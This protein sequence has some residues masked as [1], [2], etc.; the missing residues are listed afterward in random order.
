MS[1][2]RTSAL[3]TSD[4]QVGLNPIYHTFAQTFAPAFNVTNDAHIALINKVGVELGQYFLLVD[5]IVDGDMSPKDAAVR[6]TNRIFRG[7][8]AINEIGDSLD[9]FWPQL[10]ELLDRW[11]NAF[12][13]EDSFRNRTRSLEDCSLELMRNL[14][15]D[16]GCM[17]GGVPA[18][19]AAVSTNPGQTETLKLVQTSIDVFSVTQQVS[20]DLLDWPHDLQA[21]RPS[22]VFAAC[23]D[24]IDF[25][26]PEA[27]EIAHVLYQDG[28]MEHLITEAVGAARSAAEAVQAVAP[29]WTKVLN[30]SAES[31]AKIEPPASYVA[32]TVTISIPAAKQPNTSY[33]TLLIETLR[34]YQAPK[35]LSHVM[36][37]SEDLGVSCPG[38]YAGDVFSRALALGWLADINSNLDDALSEVLVFEAEHLAR[39]RDTDG[40]MLWR[41][42]PGFSDLAVDLDTTAEVGRSLA[43][44]G[45][46]DSDG[47]QLIWGALR[48][49]FDRA[50]D[51]PLETWLYSE[52]NPEIA[53]AERS[54]STRYWG[55]DYDVEVA[56]NVLHLAHLLDPKGFEPDIRHHV[57]YLMDELYAGTEAT[58]YTNCGYKE[59]VL[60]RLFLSLGQ[61]KQAIR[62]A[63]T[64]T[65]KRFS[66]DD[67]LFYRSSFLLLIDEAFKA[68]NVHIHFLSDYDALQTEVWRQVHLD[69]SAQV[70]PEPFIVMDLG[71]AVPAEPSEA[72]LLFYQS[73]LLQKVLALRVLDP[74]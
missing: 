73:R 47:R 70:V 62:Q 64:L 7:C 48:R 52:S 56:A 54:A 43:I 59:Y 18:L 5:N 30:K 6:F 4:P 66:S 36:S 8:Q 22:F 28:A 13:I 61:Q 11:F 41:Y 44:N 10:F 26:Q 53:Q 45:F 34:A 46:L 57:G 1:D 27:A 37:F 55:R 15:K 9:S 69:A 67:F 25:T 49:A 21:R 60:T 31:L 29:A 65:E 39:R 32:R 74:T 35:A 68:A 42:F 58:W 17:A 33:S 63:E 24:R 14:A 50:G 3:R 38:T 71:R 23:D 12:E 19:L 72:N 16:R 51:G 20:D 2:P 40:D